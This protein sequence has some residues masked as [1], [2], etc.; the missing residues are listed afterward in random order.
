MDTTI[1]MDTTVY[2]LY[3]FGQKNRGNALEVWKK[4]TLLSKVSSKILHCNIYF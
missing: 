3:W 2:S 1:Y 4:L